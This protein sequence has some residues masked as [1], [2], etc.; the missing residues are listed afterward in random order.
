[1]TI[2]AV[3]ER[4][5]DFLVGNRI[6]PAFENSG[7][8]QR[9]RAAGAGWLPIPPSVDMMA[10][11]APLKG[12][13]YRHK[14]D[15]RCAF[16]VVNAFVVPKVNEPKWCS[17]K[18]VLSSTSK[19][20]SADE[21]LKTSCTALQA[22][23]FQLRTSDAAD[24]AVL[25]LEGPC[26]PRELPEPYGKWL[27][28]HETSAWDLQTQLRLAVGLEVSSQPIDARSETFRDTLDV[29]LSAFAPSVVEGF[30]ERQ[31][32]SAISTYLVEASVS[33]AEIKQRARSNLIEV[34]RDYIL[35]IDQTEA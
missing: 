5:L 15:W 2:N 6:L 10:H 1:M 11:Y 27:Q 29:H 23:G 24:S 22:I 35:A 8:Y 19:S 13:L 18:K 14:E 3:I 25:V 31:L 32:K 7:K 20:F 30:L 4:S 34:G 21:L 17:L 16:A 9:S 12:A 28:Y 26:T 33:A